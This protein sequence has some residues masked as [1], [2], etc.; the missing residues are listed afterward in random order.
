MWTNKD[1]AFLTENYTTLTAVEIAEQLGRTADS[2]SYMA[3]R[4]GLA[5]AK[6]LWSNA[7][8][9]FLDRKSVV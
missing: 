6:S 2:V 9:D 4:L 5:A 3:C 1:K 8:V 7:D